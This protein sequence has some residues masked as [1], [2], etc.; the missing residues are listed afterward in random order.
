MEMTNLNQMKMT[1]LNQ[2]KM[3]K[4][5]LMEMTNL[6]QMMMKKILQMGMKKIN[7]MKMTNLNQMK[8]TNLKQMKMTKI[9]M[10]EMT[11]LNQMLM[12]TLNLMRMTKMNPKKKYTLDVLKRKD[13]PM[14]T[15]A[16]EDFSEYNDKN[17]ELGRGKKSKSGTGRL[18]SSGKSRGSNAHS[19]KKVKPLPHKPH[20]DDPKGCG[21]PICVVIDRRVVRFPS[22]CQYSKFACENSRKNQVNFI[23]KGDCYDIIDSE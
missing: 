7:L 23:Q 11:N 20:K 14:G 21:N 12:T 19:Q 13:K 4:I 2:M 8:M 15:F 5:N 10:M 3:T 22:I 6:N 1:N 16:E 9:N 17:Y 18:R